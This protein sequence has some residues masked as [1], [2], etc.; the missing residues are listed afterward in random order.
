MRRHDQM[1]VLRAH[2]KLR[3]SPDIVLPGRSASRRLVHPCVQQMQPL[4]ILAVEAANVGARPVGLDHH[5]DAVQL[6]VPRMEDVAR[7]AGIRLRPW[8]HRNDRT[9]R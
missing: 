4:L 2:A 5:G 6:V 9:P 7:H 8:P 1:F 3:A